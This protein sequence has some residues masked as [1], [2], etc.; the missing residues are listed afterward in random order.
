MSSGGT[1]LSVCRIKSFRTE[2]S[3]TNPSL[4]YNTYHSPKELPCIKIP[5]Q[6]SLFSVQVLQGDGFSGQHRCP[7][8]MMS[9]RIPTRSLSHFPA[10]FFCPFTTTKYTTFFTCPVHCLCPHPAPRMY[11]SHYV[12]AQSS[13]SVNIC[14]VKG[15]MNLLIRRD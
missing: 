8:C 3:G 15:D 14:C 1:S 2:D 10:L 12:L 6:P 13:C 9:V 7:T 5:A 11:I 4:R